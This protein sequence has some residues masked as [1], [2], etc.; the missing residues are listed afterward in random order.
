MTGKIMTE[1]ELQ[2]IEKRCSDAKPAPW[3]WE[4]ED[5][6]MVDLLYTIQGGTAKGLDDWVLAC[7]RCYSCQ[8]TGNYCTWPQKEDADFIS[9]ARTDVPNLVVEVRRLKGIV[10]DANEVMLSEGIIDEEEF[11]R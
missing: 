2:E 7:A 3:H 8:K 11:E 1:Q 9:H 4:S 6:S 10:Q 5:S